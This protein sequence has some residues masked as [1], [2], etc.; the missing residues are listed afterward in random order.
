MTSCSPF[1]RLRSPVD[2]PSRIDRQPMATGNGAGD[3]RPSGCDSTT[4]HLGHSALQTFV[5][6][7]HARVANSSLCSSG[8]ASTLR[9]RV[10]LV[11]Q[12]SP[13]V[14]RYSMRALRFLALPSLLLLA[15]CSSSGTA[16]P[17]AASSL[18][19][20]GPASPLTA[21]PAPAVVA[22]A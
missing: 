22:P 5:A 7:S 18:V 9:A 11:V 6:Q 20:S 15:A 10:N 4:F 2:A 21:A 3:S 1:E 13:P 14:R 17:L 19:V 12:L 16:P 8:V